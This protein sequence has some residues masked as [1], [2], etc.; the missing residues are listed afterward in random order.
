M[1]EKKNTASQQVS[2]EEPDQMKAI[3]LGLVALSL[4][5][6]AILVSNFLYTSKKVLK[7]NPKEAQSLSSPRIDDS[8]YENKTKKDSPYSPL[9]KT[10]QVNINKIKILPKWVK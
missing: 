9:P 8:P 5:G 7:L 1:L 3:M 10:K 4:I 2:K 6:S